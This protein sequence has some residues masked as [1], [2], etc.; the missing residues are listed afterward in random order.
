MA[1][2]QLDP[3]QIIWLQRFTYPA[4]S[5]RKLWAF[6]I[7]HSEQFKLQLNSG[8]SVTT[9]HFNQVFCSIW[10]YF[11]LQEIFFSCRDSWEETEGWSMSSEINSLYTSLLQCLLVCIVNFVTRARLGAFDKHFNQL[12]Y[13]QCQAVT[14]PGLSWTLCCSTCSN[15]EFIQGFSAQWLCWEY[16]IVD[17]IV[18]SGTLVWLFPL[19]WDAIEL[20]LQVDF[21][22][23]FV[24]IDPTDLRATI[25]VAQVLCLTIFNISQTILCRIIEFLRRQW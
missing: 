3:F 20:T 5:D 9:V 19:A 7:L 1:G 17:T 24:V 21:I 15:E 10:Q 18:C 6:Q 16:W 2:I 25:V 13:Y 23:P 4:Y 11:S 14:H 22:C 12:Y 8:L